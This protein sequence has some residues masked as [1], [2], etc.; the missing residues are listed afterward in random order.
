MYPESKIILAS[1][2]KSQAIETLEKILEMKSSS[3]LLFREID[4]IKTGTNDARC[5]FKNGSWIR[6]VASN[7]G[8][9][10]KRANLIVVDEFVQVDKLI[11]DS[12]LKKFMSAPR[13]PK[14]L[15]KKQYSHLKERNKE[16]Y[17]SSCWFKFHWSWDKTKAFFN[18]MVDGKEYFIC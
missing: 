13:Q 18:S 1:G 16:I 15:Q 3:P 14:Y 17:L 12:V 8:A 4:E 7:Q 5:T 2:N 10:S 11:I 6:V 9:R